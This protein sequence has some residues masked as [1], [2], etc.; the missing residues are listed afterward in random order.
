MKFNIESI[1]RNEKILETNIIPKHHIEKENYNINYVNKNIIGGIYQK[2][3]F[4]HILNLLFFLLLPTLSYENT[5]NITLYMEGTSGNF[6]YSGF[7]PL[8]DKI[9]INGDP[10][11]EISASFTSSVSPNVIKLVWNSA[12]T[13]CSSMFYLIG[14]KKVDLSEFNSDNVIDMSKMFY[15]C[16]KLEEIIF[17]NLDTSNVVNMDSMF[18]YNS[19]ITYMDLPNLDAS[20]VTSMNSMFAHC[21]GLTSIDLSKF[22]TSSSLL[23]IAKM[24]DYCKKL[25]YIDLSNFDTSRVTLFSS[26]FSSC[27]V[28]KSVNLNNLNTSSVE[29]MISLF[30]NCKVLQYIDISS[31]DLSKVTN[32]AS[33]FYLCNDLKEIKFNQVYKASKIQ[34]TEKMFQSCKNLTSLDLSFM[35]TSLVLNMNY[36]FNNCPKLQYLNIPNFDTASVTKATTI[37]GDG[38]IIKYLNGYS[39][40]DNSLIVT[41]FDKLPNEITFC[42]GSQAPNII[43]KLENKN[44]VNNCSATC[45]IFG[46][47]SNPVN[48][49]QCYSSCTHD[50]IYQFEYENECYEKCPGNT[51]SFTDDKICITYVDNVDTTNN[52]DIHEETT[53]EEEEKKEENEEES[54]NL[55]EFIYNEFKEEKNDN[56]DEQTNEEEKYDN[57]DESTNEEENSYNMG[58]PTNNDE[59]SYEANNEEKSYDMNEATNDGD[60][61]DKDKEEENSVQFETNFN[62]ESSYLTE[63]SSYSPSPSPSLS[64]ET[65]DVESSIYSIETIT[66]I[67]NESNLIENNNYDNLIESAEISTK[68]SI[69]NTD[70]S[71]ENIISNNIM[72]INEYCNIIEFLRNS[73]DKSKIENYEDVIKKI[74]DNIEGNNI[75]EIIEK[76]I[77]EA[78][79]DFIIDLSN[80]KQQL[81]SSYNQEHKEYNNISTINL[82]ECEALLKAENDINPNDTLIIFKVDTYEN[83][84]LMPIVEYEVYDPK[85]FKKLNLSICNN[86]IEVSYPIIIDEDEIDKYN[87][88]S[89]YYNDKCFPTKYGKGV[90]MILTDRKD[91]FINN[92][93]SLC[94]N[95]CEFSGYDKDTKKVVCECEIKNKINFINGYKIDKDKLLSKFKDI[96]NMVNLYVLKCKKIF[97]TKDGLI[98]N[99]GSYILLASIIYYTFSSF[100]FCFKGFNFFNNQIKE[101]K[102]IKESNE[103][104]NLEVNNKME[105]HPKQKNN[106]KKSKTAKN[107]KRK[108]KP[109]N[110]FEPSKKKER[111]NI[112]NKTI[113]NI[114]KSSSS[115]NNLYIFNK[116]EIK[117]ENQILFLNYNDYELNNL[118]YQDALKYD[119]RTYCEYYL[120][121]LRQK[122]LLLFSFCNNSDYNSKIIKICL[123]LF[124]FVLSFTI[125]ALFYTE[126]TIHDIY[127][128]SG[129]FDFFYHIPQ[130]IYSTAISVFINMFIKTLSLSQKNI[131]K[132]K[133]EKSLTDF[134]NKI[135]DCLRCLKIKFFLFFVFSFIF[136]AFFWYYLGCFCAVYSNTQYHVIKDSLFS[137]GLSLLY[138][139]FINL[140][141]GM[142]RI[143]SL[144]EGNKG[145]LYNFSKIIQII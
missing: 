50:E 107:K 31:F 119:K 15:Y 129:V 87:I 5:Y 42:I 27:Y 60:L 115:T 65:I 74:K 114:N 123:L 58:E 4:I 139:L 52:I 142:L 3:K 75:Q 134:D 122:H 64:T 125:N 76:I 20:K 89:D 102:R 63:Q 9:F 16:T 53:E 126:N 46:Q 25:E 2:N 84:L 57:M 138:P 35:D 18:Y 85:T 92:N 32:T 97:L 141:P 95:N 135:K 37:F 108:S 78:K 47:K 14:I 28:L 124:T 90:D 43:S 86:K 21:E 40:T 44:G 128:N 82:K 22:K 68:Q 101:I 140:I 83:G 143:P 100:L 116:R 70:N 66:S 29:N 73:C 133:E 72:I 71:S 54:Y 51:T 145:C 81:T 93:Y 24:F 111:K 137:F 117:N 118:S 94:E 33:M 23:D 121:L 104:V 11:S 113:S 62:R 19:L 38:Y 36:M 112:S 96:K 56:M 110:K 98:T 103:I 69:V 7:E 91:E 132:L 17:G 105:F 48:K 136:L 59:K 130:I 131:L 12:V 39:L 13:N 144:K 45:E 99:I 80:I 61:S 26:L 88:S 49:N 120:S 41:C 34:T 67:K 1:K 127:D 79:E 8:P 77:G 30:S 10:V 55:Y 6:L 106:I 109:K